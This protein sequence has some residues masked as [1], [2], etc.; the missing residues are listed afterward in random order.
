MRRQLLST[1]NAL[2]ATILIVVLL[3][4]C[5]FPADSGGDQERPPQTRIIDVLVQPD[6]VAPGDTASFTCI[7]EDSLDK[8]FKFYWVI[9]SGLA[10]NG[11]ITDSDY[12]SRYRTDNNSMKWESPQEAGFY[13][14]EVT[15]NNGSK[16]SVG[17]RSS[18][19]IVVEQ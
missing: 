8:R 1:I 12:P 16:D 17:V 18:F 10:L 14:F 9:D 11:E 13:S 5:G 4:A 3:H 19:S 7:I 6:T 2:L 15:A